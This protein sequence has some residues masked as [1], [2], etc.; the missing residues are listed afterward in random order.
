MGWAELSLKV[1]ALHKREHQI[2]TVWHPEATGEVLETL[3]LGNIRV[4]V[5]PARYQLGTGE[6]IEV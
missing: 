3:H 4:L 1:V 6:V 5:G 2:A